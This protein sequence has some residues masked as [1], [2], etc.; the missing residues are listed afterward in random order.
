MP[1]LADLDSASLSRLLSALCVGADQPLFSVADWTARLGDSL[2]DSL[3]AR[4]FSA[5]LEHEWYPLTIPDKLCQQ[6]M[7]FARDYLVTYEGWPHLWAH[8]LRVTGTALAIAPEAG[9]D[10]DHAFLLG[11]FHDVG[12]LDEMQS[13][14][15]HE[16]VGADLV[17]AQLSDYYSVQEIAL[18]TNAIAKKAS[19]RNPYMQLLSDAD[20]LD[21]IGA[22]GIARRVSIS[23]QADAQANHHIMSLL[24]IRQDMTNFPLMHFPTSQAL[25]DLKL[26][27]TRQFFAVLGFP[28]GGNDLSQV[29]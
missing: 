11:V 20:K 29:R 21:K 23:A 16:L 14:D 18:I 26:D 28:V 24:R 1:S 15:S 9:V 7:V 22:T 25:A 12:K 10:Q 2:G 19:P 17:R 3:E 5:Q 8:I 27:F 4:A 13:G 6:M